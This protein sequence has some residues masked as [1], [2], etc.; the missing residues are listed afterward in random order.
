MNIEI[1]NINN[2][3]LYSEESSDYVIN[4]L[5]SLDF[6][7][8]Y[9]SG[10]QLK[11]LKL[12]LQI[13]NSEFDEPKYLQAACETSVCA[14]I[15]KLYPSAFFYEHKVN[16]PKDVD[17][18]FSFEE[19]TFNIEIKCPDFTRDEEIDNSNS[20][21]LGAFGRFEEYQSIFDKT[22]SL[23]NPAEKPLVKKLHM[24]NKLKDFLISSN[25][26]FNSNSGSNVLNVL[27]VCCDTAMDMQDWFFYM[28]GAQGLFMDDS[29]HP[30]VE[31]E[32]VDVVVLSNL[33]HRHKN[34]WEKNKITEHWS[35]CGA[36]N[37]V[38]SNTKHRIAKS[39][40]IWKF[41]D[42]IPNHSRPFMNYEIK[43]IFEQLRIP[44]FVSEELL[45]NGKYYFQ[46]NI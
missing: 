40:A 5:P 35:L 15:A 25:S 30:Q 23:F 43:G 16:P 46:P 6:L 8:P 1:K 33:Y 14:S 10:A 37:L 19:F 26:K 21:K 4:L 18:A 17:C 31:Y 2:K 34:Y 28:Y 13:E 38:F 45:K 42:S 41:V 20:F 11:K 12:D 36:F 44:E 32:N 24:D 7:V 29:Y 39:K 22:A 27:W 9:L 3:Y